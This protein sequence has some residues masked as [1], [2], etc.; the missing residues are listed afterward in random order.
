LHLSSAGNF[1][2]GDDASVANDVDFVVK[3]LGHSLVEG[4]DGQSISDGEGVVAGRRVDVTV[5]DRHSHDLR[6]GVF[7][8]VS[9][10]GGGVAGE[11]FLTAVHNSPFWGGSVDHGDDHSFRTGG[12]VGRVPIPIESTQAFEDVGTDSGLGATDGGGDFG[13]PGSAAT[14]RAEGESG[15]VGKC[16]D[17][18]DERFR[19]MVAGV[20]HQAV[21]EKPICPVDLVRK[22]DRRLG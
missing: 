8:D 7:D 9:V 6:V 21:E 20:G 15:F 16:S 22:V 11:G 5:L 1:P 19:P 13:G 12:G 17:P 14:D 18:I 2:G 3:I 10:G 4:D